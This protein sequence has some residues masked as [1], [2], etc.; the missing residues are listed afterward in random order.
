[1]VKEND[2]MIFQ[3]T[4]LDQSPRGPVL[5][6]SPQNPLDVAQRAAQPDSAGGPT[7]VPTGE[8]AP[9]SL[10]PL[11]A[12][13]A[14]RRALSPWLSVLFQCFQRELEARGEQWEGLPEVSCFLFFRRAA[15]CLW[16][17]HSRAHI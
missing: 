10:C 2:Y 13:L 15:S 9:P 4:H 3:Q 16:L 5:D 17:P 7:P 12:L 14:V 11:T 8:S 1:M 6:E